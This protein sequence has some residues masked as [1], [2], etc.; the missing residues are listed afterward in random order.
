MCNP[1]AFQ[2]LYQIHPYN[3]TYIQ[4]FI[5]YINRN[6]VI[7]I[8]DYYEGIEKKRAYVVQYKTEDRK[9]VRATMTNFGIAI[10]IQA[11]RYIF[12]LF[13]T[14]SYHV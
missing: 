2:K 10:P 9:T 12:F 4:G 1:L 5:Q 8:G 13:K 14:N 3:F 7:E 11:G 6:K